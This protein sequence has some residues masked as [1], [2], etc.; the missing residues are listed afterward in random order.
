[1]TRPLPA[2][3]AIA[4]LALPAIAG[5]CSSSDSGEPAQQ[6]EKA[7]G[8]P[9]LSKTERA[10]GAKACE[11][12]AERVCACADSDPELEADCELARARPEALEMAAGASGATGD[13]EPGDR[14]AARQT[15]RQIIEKC[16]EA[17]ARLDP[18]RCPRVG[19]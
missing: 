11:R 5:G 10:R 2:L 19:D 14:A 7:P 4:L 15:A 17:Q 3:L 12:Y 13:L 6:T 8:P 1:M 9:P 18:A 16:V